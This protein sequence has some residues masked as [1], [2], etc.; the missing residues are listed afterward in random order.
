MKIV[1]A[2]GWSPVCCGGISS[3]FLLIPWKTQ[4]Q[5]AYLTS[6]LLQSGNS[7]LQQWGFSLNMLSTDCEI[8]FN[9]LWCYPPQM[10]HG[11]F[12]LLVPQQ[13]CQQ[14]PQKKTTN[15]TAWRQLRDIS[16]PTHLCIIYIYILYMY[17]GYTGAYAFK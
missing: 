13:I 1:T 7:M 15:C 17:R 4:E 2:H 10:L 11:I 6:G 8:P 9:S 3:N 12:T 14:K 16:T 5:N